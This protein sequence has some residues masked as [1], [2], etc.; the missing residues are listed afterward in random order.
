MLQSLF[1][2]FTEAKSQNVV[3]GWNT[4]GKFLSQTKVRQEWVKHV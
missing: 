4:A 1:N 2:N 3:R